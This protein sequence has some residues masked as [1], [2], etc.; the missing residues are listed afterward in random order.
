MCSGT[1]P[2]VFTI[3]QVF[4]Q[5]EFGFNRIASIVEYRIVIGS[6]VHV[7]AVFISK[8]FQKGIDSSSELSIV[9][10]TISTTSRPLYRTFTQC[11]HF[12]FSS[13]YIVRHTEGL[14]RTTIRVHTGKQVKQVFGICFGFFSYRSKVTVVT[15]HVFHFACLRIQYRNLGTRDI[16]FFL[17]EDCQD[18]VNVLLINVDTAERTESRR[19]SRIVRTNIVVVVNESLSQVIA[20]TDFRHS[21]RFE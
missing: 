12:A 17:Q 13:R 19:N 10:F 21:T 16:Q 14:V 2:T 6:I 11:S 5:I 3:S 9:H 7:L 20:S 18:G 4:I 8:V 15:S 1:Y